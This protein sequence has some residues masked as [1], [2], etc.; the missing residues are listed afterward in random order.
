MAPGHGTIGSEEAPL[1]FRC[2]YVIVLLP[3]RRIKKIVTDPAPPPPLPFPHYYR[4][5][6][7]IL[8]ILDACVLQERGRRIGF[9]NRAGSFSS[10]LRLAPV[11]AMFFL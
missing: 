7:R 1:S 10:G 3:G 4:G 8:F 5:R 2:R 6:V 11:A 9:P